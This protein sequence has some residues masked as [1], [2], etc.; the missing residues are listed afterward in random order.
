V[1]QKDGAADDEPVKV[2]DIRQRVAET[3]ERIGSVPDL[4]L[5]HNRECLHGG[6]WPQSLT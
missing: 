4:F 1:S 5:I 3:T 6:S 2:E